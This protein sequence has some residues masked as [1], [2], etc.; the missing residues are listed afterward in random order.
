MPTI[1]SFSPTSGP[2]GCVVVITGTSFT[3][4]P[5]AQTTVSFVSPDAVET[6]ATPFVIVSATEILATVP[7]LTLG[8]GYS[9]RVTNPAGTSPSVGTF[10]STSGA[11]ACAPTIA[12]FSPT[13]GPVGTTVTITGTNLLTDV[14]TGGDVTFFDNKTASPSG[15]PV[16][17]SQLSV[18]VPDGAV[19]GPITVTTPRGAATSVTTFTVVVG[20]GP[21]PVR[22]P[23]QV[24][25]QT[26]EGDGCADAT[27][28]PEGQTIFDQGLTLAAESNV[29]VYISFELGLETS[30]Q[31]GLISFG[32][33][34][35]GTD[36]EWGVAAP[37]ST[38]AKFFGVRQSTTLMWTFDHVA[39]GEHSVQAFARVSTGSAGMNGC[40]LTVLVSPVAE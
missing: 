38:T 8:I 15:G 13:S 30:R 2:A 27:L 6:P 10:L 40:A 9:I 17:P 39:A 20:P 11:G 4:F 21:P 29:T 33:D 26:F 25:T 19:T 5:A 18:L 16:G 7:G 12:S 22:S 31:E 36:Q 34:G 32:L 37:G 14:N 28:N 1:T 23:I 24:F 35:T 3:D